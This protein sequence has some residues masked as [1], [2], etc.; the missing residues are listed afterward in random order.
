MTEDPQHPRYG[1]EEIRRILKRASAMQEER[2]PE[3]EGLT[4][5]E[6]QQIAAEAGIDPRFVA[7]AAEA[8]QRGDDARRPFHLLGGGL[9][10]LEERSFPGPLTEGQ[11]DEILDEIRRTFHQAGRAGKVGRT[12]E[13]THAAHSDE[14]QVTISERGDRT[15]VRVLE[16]FPRLAVL[17]YIVPLSFLIPVIVNV[18]LLQDMSAAGAA[19]FALFVLALGFTGS[20]LG[21]SRIVAK[22]ER[23]A[24]QLLDRIEQIAAIPEAAPPALSEQRTDPLGAALQEGPAPEASEAALRTGRQVRG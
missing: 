21:Y 22:K 6:L 7:L 16:R 1:E 19:L 11:R 3:T 4:L 12:T 5:E 8:E 20:R 10:I 9:S 15:T 17:T 18:P 14:I 23:R 13:W 24:R 2:V